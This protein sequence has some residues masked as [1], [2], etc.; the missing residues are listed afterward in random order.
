[1]GTEHEPSKLEVLMAA[2]KK[3]SDS[4]KSKTLLVASTFAFIVLGY[5]FYIS[6]LPMAIGILSLIYSWILI[7]AIKDIR[8]V[9]SRMPISKYSKRLAW[10]GLIVLGICLIIHLVLPS[11]AGVGNGF[12]KK[13][14]LPDSVE[15]YF[16]AQ[17]FVKKHLKAPATADFPSYSNQ[18]INISRR[19]DTTFLISG[20]V[21]A[22]NSFGANLRTNYKCEIMYVGNDLWQLVNINILE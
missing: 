8:S 12:T 5:L 10:S 1:M 13:R 7:F 22:Q 15:A 2:S 3:R 6:G 11:P 16:M 18:D 14:D 17:E 9:T 4:V 21:D 20:F 19:N